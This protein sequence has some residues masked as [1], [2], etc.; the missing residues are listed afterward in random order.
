[1]ATGSTA[2][3]KMIAE[4]KALIRRHWL[5]DSGVPNMPTVPPSA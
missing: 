5:I 2:P 1:M 3:I 4:P